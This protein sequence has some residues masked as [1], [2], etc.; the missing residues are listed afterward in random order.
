MKIAFITALPYGSVANQ[1]YKIVDAASK[2]G[3]SCYT[4]TKPIKGFETKRTN[5]FFEQ[6]LI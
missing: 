2:K 1:M 3:H 4:F 6:R 5:H